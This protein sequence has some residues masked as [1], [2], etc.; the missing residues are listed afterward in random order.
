MIDTINLTNSYLSRMDS[1]NE[2]GGTSNRLYAKGGLIA[3]IVPSSFATLTHTFMAIF[4]SFIAMPLKFSAKILFFGQLDIEMTETINSIKS[5]SKLALRFAAAAIAIPIFAVLSNSSAIKI[6][7][8]LGFTDVYSIKWNQ[9]SVAA[10][11]AIRVHGNYCKSK[12]K[13]KT[14][15]NTLHINQADYQSK[16]NLLPSL[17]NRIVEIET[18]VQKQVAELPADKPNLVESR[19][20]RLQNY[21]WGIKKIDKIEEPSRSQKIEAIQKEK[22]KKITLIQN[23]IIDLNKVKRLALSATKKAK[24]Y[25]NARIHAYSLLAKV[26]RNDLYGAIEGKLESYSKNETIQPPAKITL[27][28]TPQASSSTGIAIKKPKRTKKPKEATVFVALG[29]LNQHSDKYKDD[30]IGHKINSDGTQEPVYFSVAA[31]TPLA[32][33]FAATAKEAHNGKQYATEATPSNHLDAYLGDKKRVTNGIDELKRMFT[34]N[35]GLSLDRINLGGDAG[36]RVINA[37]LDKPLAPKKTY[38]GEG[39][40]YFSF[41]EMTSITQF[42]WQITLLKNLNKGEG[43][44][45]ILGGY[46]IGIRRIEDSFEIFDSHNSS[47]YTGKNG[48]CVIHCTNTNDLETYLR[49]ICQNGSQAGGSDGVQALAQ[50]TEIY[51]F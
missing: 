36:L 18:E 29:D 23:E 28:A 43:A 5:N 40:T 10:N 49:L 17:A 2:Q 46:S 14:L 22:D 19:F 12:E 15:L 33:A 21:I 47:A 25:N 13:L 51:I 48:A 41:Q 11:D 24:K 44:L 38:T 3:T 31:C 1:W 7:D 34:E 6:G 37:M 32:I 4:H 42:D 35:L 39:N 16:V 20:I 30:V 27:N 8:T 50:G 26:R 9:A 45:V